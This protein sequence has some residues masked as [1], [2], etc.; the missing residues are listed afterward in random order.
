M[1]DTEGLL[2]GINTAIIG[3]SGGNI[4]IG[5][6]IPINMVSQV[7]R[8]II[9]YG[10]IQRGHLGVQVQDLTPAVAKRLDIPV[11]KGALIAAVAKVRHNGQG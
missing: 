6:A 4:G 9:K 11:D 10:N 1:L 8:Q 3:P 7:M 2:I 5:F